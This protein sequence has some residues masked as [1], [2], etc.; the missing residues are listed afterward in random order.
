VSGIDGPA[1]SK[2]EFT[3]L[4]LLDSGALA[5]PVKLRFS[6]VFM[7]GFD[8]IAG[9]GC[10]QPQRLGHLMLMV[11]IMP[12]RTSFTPVYHTHQLF[13]CCPAISL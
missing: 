11:G 3:R 1:T 13:A 4:V 10:C 5:L 6:G 2:T 12:L 9:K 7:K 8:C